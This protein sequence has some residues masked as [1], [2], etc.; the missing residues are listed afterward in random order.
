MTDTLLRRTGA[1]LSALALALALTACGGDDTGAGS[2]ASPTSAPVPSDAELSGALL[3]VEDLPAGYAETPVEEDDD[4]SIFDGS[5]LE[6]VSKFSE[7]VGSDP[8]SESE[9]E[10]TAEQ[11][12]GEAQVSSSLDV[13]ADEDDVTAAFGAFFES[14]QGCDNVSFTDADG[15]SYDLDV[16]ASDTVGLN[17]VDQQ[18][19]IALEGTVEA[20]GQ[21]I[22]IAFRFLA[23]QQGAA[24]TAVGTS[25]IGG[26]YGINDQLE[27]LAQ[28]QADRFTDVLGR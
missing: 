11:P 4:N 21:S 26:S 20:P 12:D 25:E 5:C 2:D 15:V 1:S 17:G 9:T 22:T 18:L 19:T 6:N 16:T 27:A 28:I 23:A 8:V 14:M 10:F 13:Y 7:Q 24:T 3:T